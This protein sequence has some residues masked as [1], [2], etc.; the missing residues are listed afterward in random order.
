MMMMMM[1][2][3]VADKKNIV[4]DEKKSRIKKKE[5]R[6]EKAVKPRPNDHNM[7]T[8][9]IATLLAQHVGCVWPPCCDVLRHVGCCWLTF[10]I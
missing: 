9:H 5:S 1:I 7:P 6:I 10:Q 4:A 3:K 2:K 8:Q